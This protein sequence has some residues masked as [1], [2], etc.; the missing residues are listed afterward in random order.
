MMKAEVKS[1]SFSADNKFLALASDSLSIHIFHIE[2]FLTEDEGLEG[3]VSKIKSF[4]SFKT[5]AVQ[6]I[7]EKKVIEK[8]KMGKD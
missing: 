2:H 7:W 1:L 5:S 6:D 8:Q 3:G 4:M